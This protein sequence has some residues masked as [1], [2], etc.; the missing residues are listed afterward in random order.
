MDS[1]MELGN[2]TQELNLG[3]VLLLAYPFS[4]NYYA[5]YIGCLQSC[6]WN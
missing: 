5:A 1:E 6:L 3:Q 2:G 4:F